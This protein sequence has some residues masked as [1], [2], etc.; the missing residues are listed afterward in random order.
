MLCVQ[1]TV[2]WF[3]YFDTKKEGFVENGVEEMSLMKYFR[4]SKV[5]NIQPFEWQ[6]LKPHFEP[7]NVHTAYMAYT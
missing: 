7:Q 4:V 2:R 3:L 5:C 1:I 6:L